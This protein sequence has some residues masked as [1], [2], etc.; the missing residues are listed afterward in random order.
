MKTS[1]FKFAIITIIALTSCSEDDGITPPPGPSPGSSVQLA[2]T[3]ETE[4]DQMGQFADNAMALF[5]GK[6]WSVGGENSYTSGPFIVSSDV[7]SSDNGVNWA[8]VTSN[9]FEARRGHSLTVFDN[10]L[11]LIGGVTN[12]STYLDDIWYSED[13]TTW[14]EATPTTPYFGEVYY[15]NAFVFNSKLYVIAGSGANASVWSSINGLE[16]TLETSNAFPNRNYAKTVI[17]GGDIYII[18]GL[19][20]SNVG[21]NE[22]WK[23][24]DGINWSE[25]ITSAPLFGARVNHTA[26]VYNDKVWVI[27][28]REAGTLS[29][30]GDIWYSSNMEDWEEYEDIEG[31][32]GIYSHVTLLY[33]DALWVF[34]GY[35]TSGAT[36]RIV[37]IEEL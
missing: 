27:A 28:G 15:H 33:N 14:V 26:T 16:W 2:I 4:E 6:I 18:G 20:V 8:S 23:S 35:E 7:W 31:G 12:S 36:G 21:L 3:T 17:F 34:G 1:F 29:I 5:N 11:W 30:Y 37:K 32:G 9:V 19:S 10:K 22:I 24:A 25:V 13:G